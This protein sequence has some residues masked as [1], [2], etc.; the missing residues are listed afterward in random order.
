[1]AG[2]ASTWQ[3]CSPPGVSDATQCPLVL[4]VSWQGWIRLAT[5]TQA[6]IMGSQ[7][8]QASLQL[9]VVGSVLQVACATGGEG[10]TRTG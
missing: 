6:S 1:M 7:V 4:P 3:V 5:S 2:F 9:P 8:L 10:S